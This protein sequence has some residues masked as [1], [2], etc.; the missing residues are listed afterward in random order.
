MSNNFYQNK[1]KA[2]E[3]NYAISVPCFYF[4][5][6]QTHIQSCDGICPLDT[7]LLKE[8]VAGSES[9][10]RIAVQDKVHSF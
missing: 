6:P 5:R 10:E 3:D 2:Q 7:I 8:I 1:I 9:P 4:K